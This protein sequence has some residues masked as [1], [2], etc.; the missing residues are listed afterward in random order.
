[1]INSSI[2]MY[3]D[4]KIPTKKEKAMRKLFACLGLFLLAYLLL[5]PTAVYAQGPEIP[6]TPKGPGGIVE[7]LGLLLENIREFVEGLLGGGS[8]PLP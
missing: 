2:S 3:N 4:L 8:E 6:P 1:M 5:V 7:F